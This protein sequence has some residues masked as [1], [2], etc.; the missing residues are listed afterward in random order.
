[1]LNAFRNWIFAYIVGAG[2][3][4]TLAGWFTGHLILAGTLRIPGLTQHAWVYDLKVNSGYTV[5]YV[6][7]NIKGKDDQRIVM[8]KGFLKAFGLQRNGSF[9]Y[10]VL[11]DTVRG[12]MHLD[13]AAPTTSAADRWRKIG[14]APASIS[15]ATSEELN[16]A[17]ERSYFVIEG[18]DVANVVFDCYPAQPDVYDADIALIASQLIHEMDLSDLA[19][20]WRL[21]FAPVVGSADSP[22]MLPRRV[23]KN[24]RRRNR[25]RNDAPPDSR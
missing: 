19:K 2:A 12:Y 9:S 14:Q 21:T 24:R 4:G 11:T 6:L 25:R 10:I 5:A 1:M 15:R 20:D 17:S 23:R 16:R 13:D 22:E 18:E 8:Y 3:L 7:T